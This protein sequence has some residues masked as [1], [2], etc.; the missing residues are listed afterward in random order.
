MDVIC[1]TGFGLDVNSQRDPNNPFVEHSKALLEIDI[2]RNPVFIVA[3]KT[4]C[5]IYLV[6]LK[7]ES[8]YII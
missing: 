4:S 6:Q 5:I 1:S 2:A 7:R 3:R 8:L